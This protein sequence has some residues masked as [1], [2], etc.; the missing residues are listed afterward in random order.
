MEFGTAIPIAVAALVAMHTRNG[1]VALRKRALAFAWES[2][3]E[4]GEL[5]RGGE[6]RE[7]DRGKLFKGSGG[8][9]HARERRI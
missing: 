8:G 4:R 3:R 6:T 5:G 9:D 7:E 2:G 1:V